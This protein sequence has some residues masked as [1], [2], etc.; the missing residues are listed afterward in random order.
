MFRMG[1]MRCQ[2]RLYGPPATLDRRPIET[3]QPILNIAA[4]EPM[5]D[6]SHRPARSASDA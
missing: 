4:V 2:S 6:R 1:Q 5:A 3:K